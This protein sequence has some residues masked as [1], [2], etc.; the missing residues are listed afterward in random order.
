M[1]TV[2]IATD[3]SATRNGK[4]FDCSAGYCMY[5]KEENKYTGAMTK[6]HEDATISIAEISGVLMGLRAINNIKEDHHFIFL[7]DSEYVKKSITE[8]YPK[9]KKNIKN[10][11]PCKSDGQPV[12]H[13][14]LIEKAYLG[15]KKLKRVNVFKIRSHIPEKDMQKTYKEFC[16][17]NKVDISFDTY[18]MF[19]GI[20]E[21][22]DSIV[23]GKCPTELK[24]IVRF[25]NN[26]I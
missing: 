5:L 23:T 20:N 16:K 15:L 22:C 25:Y 18:K 24:E 1:K 4:K 8:W 12:M 11:V 13:F 14:D 26:S 9:W 21:T 19:V 3:G 2:I 17:I 6:L 10:G 7:L